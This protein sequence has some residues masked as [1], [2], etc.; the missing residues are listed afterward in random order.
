MIG[1][2]V[3]NNYPLN[4]DASQKISNLDKLPT[5][6]APA[7]A[8]CTTEHLENHLLVIPPPSAPHWYHRH[9]IR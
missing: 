9:Q 7:S 5:K 3:Q 2:R 8:I 4:I 6:S 1:R